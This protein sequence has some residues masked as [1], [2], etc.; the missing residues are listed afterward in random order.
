MI[1]CTF[2]A[3]VALAALAAA[4]DPPAP[5]NP[6]DAVDQA[7]ARAAAQ[8][9]P[10]VLGFQA[11]ACDGCYY[12]QQ[13]VRTSPE[14]TA[15][16]EQATFADVDADSPEGDRRVQ[17]WRIRQLPT[18]LVLDAQ[19]RELGRIAGVLTH[20]EY[21]HQ[22]RELLARSV[23]VDDLPAHV[24][25]TRAPSIAAARD[26][27]AALY[28]REDGDPAVHWWDGLPAPLKQSLD[29]DRQVHQWVLRLR[30]LQAYQASTP[31]QCVV[32]APPVFQLDLGCDRPVEVQR[33]MECTADLPQAQRQQLLGSQKVQLAQ[34]AWSRAFVGKRSCADGRAAVLAVAELDQMLG[35]P[36]ASGAILSAAIDD[37]NHRLR[38]DLRRDRTLADDLRA[39][40]DHAGRLDEL[41]ALYPRLI[42]AFPNDA[43]YEYRYARSLVSRGRAEPAL[44]H[45]ERAMSRASGRYRLDIAQ[46]WVQALI[47]LGRAAQARDVVDSTLQANGPSFPDQAAKLRALVTNA[48]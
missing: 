1:R 40:L 19:G 12:L 11:V 31:A 42:A 46:D 34:F 37:A 15:L 20:G 18:A 17:Q 27:L 5:A 3:G 45:F 9:H 26:Y 38:G 48:S 8:R 13:H 41:D 2:A 7:L 44:P 6:A 33:A 4:G 22:L 24:T 35:Y 28:A 23:P 43:V 47:K 36:K 16:G 39:Y 21:L 29:H 30:L 25:D 14:W 32:V 10:L